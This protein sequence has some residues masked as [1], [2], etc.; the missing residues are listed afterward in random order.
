MKKMI[1]AAAALLAGV[2][3]AAVPELSVDYAD[4]DN[5]DL[6]AKL[7]WDGSAAVTVERALSENGPWQTMVESS[8]G[9]WTDPATTV[10]LTYWYH[11][12]DG[13]EVGT[14]VKFVSVRRL[15]TDGYAKF[16]DGVS[17]E[18]AAKAFDGDIGSEISNGAAPNCP[19]SNTKL[20][21]VGVDFGAPTN[22][23]AFARL[24]PRNNYYT[25]RLSFL[26]LYGSAGAD[27]NGTQVS[28][29]M[30]D[31][32][33]PWDQYN[34]DEKS[35]FR[36]YKLNVSSD[37]AYRCYYV[38][39][40][41]E[42]GNDDQSAFHGNVGEMQLY[43]WT[44]DD[45]VDGSP[46]APIDADL[47]LKQ[48][49][50]NNLDDFYP[51]LSWKN[52]NCPLTI[53]RK[54]ADGAWTTIGTVEGLAGEFTDESAPYGKLLSYRLKAG[55]GAT[56]VANY[57]N[58]QT[59][60]RLRKL[61]TDGYAKFCDDNEGEAAKAF[62]GGLGTIGDSD[63]INCPDSSSLARVGVDFGLATNYVSLVRFYPRNDY[64]S[65][66]LSYLRLYGSVRSDQN[67]PQ[68]SVGKLGA[69]EAYDKD[70]P[71]QIS[72]F[73]WY[74]LDVSSEEP[75][76]CY[77]ACKPGDEGEDGHDKEFCGNVG[78]IELYGWSMDDV[79]EK[80]VSPGV[81][82]K[83]IERIAS[84]TSR[85]PKFIWN[86]AG[87]PDGAVVTI[88]RGPTQYGPWTDLADVS[89]S[90][91]Y[92]DSS[93]TPGIH[94]YR[95]KIAVGSDVEYTSGVEACTYGKFN[96]QTAGEPATEDGVEHAGDV[97]WGG[98]CGDGWYTDARKAFDGKLSS[99]PDLS[100]TPKVCVDFGLA[101]NY[102]AFV[103]AAPRANGCG[104]RFNGFAI[105]GSD[106]GGVA[107]VKS[108]DSGTR[109]TDQVSG[110]ADNV[111]EGTW[112]ELEADSSRAYRTYYFKIANGNAAEVELYGWSQTFSVSGVTNET[113]IVLTASGAGLSDDESVTFGVVYVGPGVEPDFENAAKYT[114]TVAE[115]KATQTVDAVFGARAVFYVKKGDD[116]ASGELIVNDNAGYGWKA[117]ATGEKLWEDPANWNCWA[118]DGKRHLGYPG[119]LNTGSANVSFNDAGDVSV[120]LSATYTVREFWV[121]GDTQKTISFHG[122]GADTSGIVCGNG[123]F[124]LGMNKNITFDAMSFTCNNTRLKDNVEMTLANG[125]KFSVAWW[126]YIT[127]E[128]AALHVDADSSLVASRNDDWYGVYL[129]GK[130]AWLDI[131][132]TVR[133]PRVRIG[134]NDGTWPG[135]PQA[136]A[137]K[138]ITVRGTSPELSNIREF[139]SMNE[140]SDG[141]TPVVEFIVP[142]GGYSQT[143][144][145]GVSVTAGNAYQMLG[146][147]YQDWGENGRGAISSASSVA[148]AVSP[149]SPFYASDG[150]SG[151]SEMPLVSWP[152]YNSDGHGGGIK[153]ARAVL[154]SGSGLAGATLEYTLDAN[155]IPVGI[156]AT[157]K[158]K[159]GISFFV[160]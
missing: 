32:V 151:G 153:T 89:S 155:Q 94:D 84:G 73:K 69:V 85:V 2:A 14:A 59:F 20:A 132:G 142:E 17:A 90:A 24:Y 144:L 145:C 55:S 159:G 23:V 31:A 38:C 9:T 45:A 75:Y 158:R 115:G 112:R 48:I 39:K 141:K 34:P 103:R 10:S 50:R 40:T 56:A 16:C 129:N 134:D 146:D 53:Q 131:E 96:V 72:M 41:G 51:V 15:N 86:D 68:V 133:A 54:F 150:A 91:S 79:G 138:G 120:T 160:R 28:T 37:T 35:M 4:I 93:A 78:E 65:M 43:G 100:G 42:E 66:R 128:N 98:K 1:A 127:G 101:T 7:T 147:Y 148:F 130:N 137:P 149:D 13:A 18:E 81:D 22:Y 74:E 113:G 136:Y 157:L 30:L 118:N 87:I 58:V 107:E 126:F 106:N 27:Q 123:T 47:S 71:E 33:V 19:D 111:P 8:T 109:L 82:F 121:D 140:F 105:Y 52:I 143:P 49:D 117:D 110:M 21:R 57:S 77:Y 104:T 99:F 156:K 95:L 26:R 67:G 114:V 102:V 139:T 29:G 76:R 70:H 3:T 64:Y 97:Y 5:G 108:A 25:M 122:N 80:Y 154:E 62:D 63:H 152:V 11:L 83:Y 116:Y 61:N 124:V 60:R 119:Y 88:Q 46:V 6:S 36:W 44:E 135:H 12:K 125:A 92:T